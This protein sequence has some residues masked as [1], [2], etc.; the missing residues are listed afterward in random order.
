MNAEA[1][2]QD[3]QSSGSFLGHLPTIFWQRRWLIIPAVVVLSALGLIAALLL[4]TVYRSTATLL[5]QSQE[6]PA[7]VADAQANTIIDQRIAKIRQQVL[8][9]GDLIAL[10]E[11]NDLYGEER[12]TRPMSETVDRMRKAISVQA[13]A[14]DIGQGG[15]GGDRSNT[16]AF[17]ISYDY[18]DAVKAQAVLQTLVQQFLELD[19]SASEERA[20]DTVSFLQDQATKLQSQIATL[21]GQITAIKSRNG[22]A[23]S[24]VGIAGAGDL[25]GYDAQIVSLQNQNR[26]L[27]AQTRRVVKNPLIATAEAQLE[28]AR[29]TYAE[30]HPDVVAAKQRLAQLRA[31]PV[32]S[33]A[34]DRAQDADLIRSQIQ[35]NN[36]TIAAIN[37]ARSSASSQAAVGLSNQARGPAVMEQVLQLDSRA[38]MLR[39]QYQDVSANLLKAQ[40]GARI[41]QEQKGERLSVVEPPVVP[42]KPVSPNRPLLIGGG[43]TAG[44]A[45]GFVLAL[46]TEVLLKPIR[47]VAAIEALGLRPLGVVPTLKADRTLRPT[48]N[49]DPDAEASR[50]GTLFEIRS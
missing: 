7:A 44:L 39:Q 27:S 42:D 22:L 24:S 45:L 37:R 50:S 10:I 23:L 36:D 18:R 11:Q 28:V 26:V 3:D 33:A 43:I 16:I 20:T 2:F 30:S 29:A 14:G 46:A 32:T 35:A 48:S 9:R 41:A 38:N 40:G 19:T 6:L 17:A 1:E 21:E 8:S 15:G 31:A 49:N 4:P 34:D 25:G 47:G 13:V 5:V 12:R